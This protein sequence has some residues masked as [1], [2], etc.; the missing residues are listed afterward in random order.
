MM[1]LT[2]CLLNLSLSFPLLTMHS[3]F[4][5]MAMTSRWTLHAAL[6]LFLLMIRR[7]GS[8]TNLLITIRTTTII[9][10]VI[11]M[12]TICCRLLS[13]GPVRL[14]LVLLSIYI[15]L[16]L[17]APRYPLLLHHLLWLMNLRQRNRFPLPREHLMWR[18]LRR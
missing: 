17:P 15:Y 10:A 18:Q 1:I 5:P 7:T 2:Y 14:R 11:A 12:V 6:S 8:M 4:R 3:T 16:A 9:F 13:I